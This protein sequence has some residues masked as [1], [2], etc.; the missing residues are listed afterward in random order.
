MYHVSSWKNQ[1]Q[2]NKKR[3]QT[4]KNVLFP[5]RIKTIV[6]QKFPKITKPISEPQISQVMDMHVTAELYY[7]LWPDKPRII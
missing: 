1:V 6:S 5:G 7:A 2:F 4:L 3:T